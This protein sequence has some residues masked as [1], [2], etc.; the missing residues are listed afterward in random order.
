MTQIFDRLLRSRTPSSQVMFE[1]ASQRLPGDV[2]GYGK[3]LP[4]FPIYVKQSEGGEFV[5]VDSS[6]YMDL[7]IGGGVHILGHSPGLE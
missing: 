6:H 2:A 5:D 7:L 3:F 4:P 1:R